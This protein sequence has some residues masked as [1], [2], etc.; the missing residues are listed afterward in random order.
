[1]QQKAKQR[2]ADANGSFAW[3]NAG[4]TK[5]KDKQQGMI[6]NCSC[7]QLVDQCP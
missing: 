7:S 1:M 6:G 3:Q 4:K 5:N 2:R